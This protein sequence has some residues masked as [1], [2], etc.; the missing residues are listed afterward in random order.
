[1]FYFYNNPGTQK[2]TIK[3]HSFMIKYLSRACLVVCLFFF[4]GFLLVLS[5]IMYLSCKAKA[6]KYQTLFFCVMSLS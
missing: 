3:I 5:H 6:T 4:P 1:M 2:A